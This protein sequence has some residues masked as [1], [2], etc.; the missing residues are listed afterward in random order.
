[1]N[2]YLTVGLATLAGAV[3]LEVALVPAVVIA[4]AAAV[5]PAVLP[6]LRRQLQPAIDAVARPR[7]AAPS[8]P[9]MPPEEM[10]PPT[11]LARL[12]VGQAIAKTVTFRVI[13][14]SLDFTTNYVVLGELTTAA[15]LSTFNFIAGPIFYFAHET[16]WNHLRPAPEDT[17]SVT[18]IASPAAND[19]ESQ[20]S[21]AGI[22]MSRALAKTITYRTIASVM[23]FT[24]NFVVV[25]DVATAVGLS[26]AG[27]LL[28]PFVY[29]GHEKV[30]DH[31]TVTKEPA[32]EKTI[33]VNPMARA[34]L[35]PM[36]AVG[37]PVSA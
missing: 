22:Q 4:G 27:F 31:F 5:A 16:V 26:A 1:M 30:W 13:V 21:W 8:I 11:L 23:D 18:A 36:I 28:G 7:P 2:R 14:T 10:A 24:T 20:T 25:G 3:L 34:N 9:V 33:V 37:Q 6:R 17:V 12:G 32:S 29:W 15:G 35:E 19:E